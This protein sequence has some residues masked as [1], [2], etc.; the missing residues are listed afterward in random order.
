MFACSKIQ[1]IYRNCIQ[2]RADPLCLH[3][4][5]KVMAEAVAA[6]GLLVNVMQ[7]ADYACQIVSKTD[8][9]LKS[10]DGSLIQNRDAEACAREL[11]LRNQRLLKSLETSS[12][13]QFGDRRRPAGWT[14]VDD[15][16]DLALQKLGRQCHDVARDLIELLTGLK[17]KSKL[18][19]L[20]QAL[21]WSSSKEKVEKI[22]QRMKSIQDQIDSQTNFSNRLV[23]SLVHPVVFNLILLGWL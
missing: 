14:D 13:E 20:R 23:F 10:A 4:R 7:L 21:E 16:D 19:S 17:T 18:G 1:F 12:G 2:E 15:A 5:T 11:L 6:F 22:E 3:S 8:E 9:I